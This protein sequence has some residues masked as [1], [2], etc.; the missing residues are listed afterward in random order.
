MFATQK[1]LIVIHSIYLATAAHQNKI[2]LHGENVNT[3]ILKEVKLINK[4][5]KYILLNTY[6]FLSL[7]ITL[8][9][10]FT[11]NDGSE[12]GKDKNLKTVKGNFMSQ[13]IISSCQSLC[14]RKIMNYLLSN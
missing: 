2:P 13:Y 6:L 5:F 7:V 12:Y 14:K 10:F 8:H 11:D 4:I 9:I 3:N 1:I